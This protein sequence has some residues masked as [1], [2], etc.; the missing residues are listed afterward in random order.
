MGGV[1]GWVG[2][3]KVTVD[4]VSISTAPVNYEPQ[5]I[6]L[7]PI[8]TPSQGWVGCQDWDVGSVKTWMRGVSRLSR[9]DG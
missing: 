1:S 3:V 2:G 6:M 9:V 4:G 7:I 5:S 8:H